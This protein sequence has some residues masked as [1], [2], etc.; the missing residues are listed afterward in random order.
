MERF[1][2]DLV[3]TWIILLLPQEIP[4]TKLTLLQNNN[5]VINS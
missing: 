1:K 4:L 2:A 3:S 5:S